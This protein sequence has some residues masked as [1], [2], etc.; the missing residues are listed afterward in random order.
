MSLIKQHWKVLIAMVAF[1]LVLAVLDVNHTTGEVLIGFTLVW[2]FWAAFDYFRNR[3]TFD[4]YL[5]VE[6]LKKWV[7]VLVASLLV[8]VIVR[9]IMVYFL[10]G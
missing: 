5:R 4:A 3:E 10:G 8:I 6:W 2:L 9:G 1:A 7:V